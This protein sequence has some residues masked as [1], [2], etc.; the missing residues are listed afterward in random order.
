MYI[1]LCKEGWGAVGIVTLP[2][3]KE[4]QDVSDNKGCGMLRR[5]HFSARGQ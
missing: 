5:E 2:D 3:Y 4:M 1:P